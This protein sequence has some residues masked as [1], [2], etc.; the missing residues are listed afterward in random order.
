VD[1]VIDTIQCP[2][3]AIPIA[4]VADEEAHP[5]VAGKLLRHFP[6]LHLIAR[7]DDELLE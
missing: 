5:I 3:Q 1:H 4:H 2:V 6:L 7:I